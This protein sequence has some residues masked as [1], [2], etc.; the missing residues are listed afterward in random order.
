MP[1]PVVPA[2]VPAA[3]SNGLVTNEQALTALES[4]KTHLPQ[5]F[6]LLSKQINVAQILAKSGQVG[7]V[8]VGE[9]KVGDVVIDAVKLSN[10]TA[11]LRSGSA[12]LQNV[13]MTIEL[14]FGLHWWFDIGIYSDSGD[15]NLGSL[16]FGMNVG[17]VSVPSL[18]NIH[19]AIPAVTV[20]NVSAQVSPIQNLNLGAAGFDKLAVSDTTLPAAGFTLSGLGLGSL[21]LSGLGVPEVK[22]AKASIDAFKPK[23]TV[24]LPGAK[25][26]NL[27]VPSTSIPDVSS[28]A[29]GLDAQASSRS[30][31]LN[32]G[33]FGFTLTVTPV[34]HMHVG[35]MTLHNLSLAAHVG[36][37]AVEN[38]RLP[39]EVRSILLK[40]LQLDD[41]S[42]TNV[43]L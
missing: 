36:Q 13:D 32:F 25:L 6:G 11:D 18:D 17:N 33:I 26:A 22:S 23:Q 20:S 38:V 3:V 30:F 4:L 24:V 31:S 5:L 19:M 10:T 12:F 16:W 8:K 27:D 39:V 35:A 21:N 9:V 29:F 15:E 41:V 7:E 28:G 42:V 14:Q 37:A 34:V 40:T 43:S 2:V 1:T